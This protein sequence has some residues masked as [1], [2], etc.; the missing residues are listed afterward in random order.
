V[1]TT[2]APN[3]QV[4]TGAVQEHD[5]SKVLVTSARIAFDE[6]RV[7]HIWSPVTGRVTK[8]MASLGDKVKKGQP[9]AIIT[10][11]DL[12]NAMSDLNKAR[13][14][15]VQTK[16][17]LQRQ[18]ELFA[19]HAGAGRDLEAAQANY[20]QAVAEQDRAEQK[21]RLLTAKG[22][23]GSVTQSFTLTSPIDGEVVARQINPGVEVQGQYTGGANVEL[24]TIGKLDAVWALADV[25]EQDVGRVS[26]GATIHFKL[27]A[28]PDKVFDGKVDWISG[29]LDP[30][31]RTATVRA[32]MPNPNRLLKPQMYATAAIETDGHKALAVPREAILHL[33]DKTMVIAMLGGGHCQR[34][35]VIVDEDETGDWVPVL[36]GLDAGDSVVTA[37]A[38]LMSADDKCGD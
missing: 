10:T 7:A 25:Y 35:P 12:G 17:E 29:T 5:V 19:A 24:F 30:A 22:V 18:K 28:Y 2:A 33:G 21:A 1:G 8:I 14:N 15:A 3:A 31:T 4:A 32:V 13:A 23:S 38:L 16:K 26:L 20:D 27:V 37:G 34:R 9:L 36:H 6:A 11:P